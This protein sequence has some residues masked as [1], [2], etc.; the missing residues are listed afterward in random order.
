MPHLKTALALAISFAVAG[1]DAE[2]PEEN[3]ASPTPSEVRTCSSIRDAVIR[4]AAQNGVNIVKIYEPT[5]ILDTPAKLDCSGR[6]VVSTGQQA[7]IYYRSFEDADGDRL[8][9]Y[10]ETKLN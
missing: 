2:T 4:T 7:T 9:Q 5:T 1:C 10:G 8:I 3:V 6:A